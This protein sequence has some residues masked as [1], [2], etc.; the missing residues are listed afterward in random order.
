ML[1]FCVSVSLSIYIYIYICLCLSSCVLVVAWWIGSS[2]W[3]VFVFVSASLSLF[4]SIFL[5]AVLWPKNSMAPK[6]PVT[7]HQSVSWSA[8]QLVNWSASHDPQPTGQPVTGS[9]TPAIFYVFI[10]ANLS[11]VDQWPVTGW[12]V[13]PIDRL[14]GDWPVTS[15]P[16]GWG[17]EAAWPS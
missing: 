17:H 11:P 9:Q 1:C 7:G 13:C 15:W 5:R 16:V 6:Q 10:N 8:V 14:T 3:F 12:L 2:L 4:L